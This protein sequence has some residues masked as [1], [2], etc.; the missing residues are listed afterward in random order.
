[1]YLVLIPLLAV[2]FL[3]GILSLTN[4]KHERIL[5]FAIAITLILLCA[6]KPIEHT[7]D[8]VAYAERYNSLEMGD[9]GSEPLS[10]FLVLITR[11]FHTP[12]AM[13][14]LYAILSIGIKFYAIHKYSPFVF[15]SIT[16]YIAMFFT[17]DYVTIRCAVAASVALLSIPF[18]IERQFGKFLL[19]V[20][21]GTLFHY[22]AF[23]W[24]V[25]YF[26]NPT[27]INLK[28]WISLPILSYIVTYLG[29][30]I[31]KCIG[32]IP[33][34]FIR[35]IYI[36]YTLKIQNDNIFATL[37]L[38]SLRQLFLIFLFFVFALNI[39]TLVKKNAYACILFK[40]YTLSLCFFCVFSDV[41]AIAMRMSSFL[42]ISVI[43]L[44]PMLVYVFKS[45]VVGTIVVL[46]IAS[47]FMWEIIYLGNIY[48]Q[49]F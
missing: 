32:Y 49:D 16:V 17:Q 13:F 23:I 29:I 33:F 46:A 42:Q 37:N 39:K 11:P 4:I 43:F 35:D 31:S 15:L 8:A 25:V 47:V 45:R 19:Y 3:S 48:V 22:S 9:F 1:M 38:F 21:I 12:I 26:L 10:Y 7:Y 6:F 28:K 14:A 24:I 20:L 41:P 27:H 5:M 18:V 2:F 30:G 34:D 36:V 44:F 40:I